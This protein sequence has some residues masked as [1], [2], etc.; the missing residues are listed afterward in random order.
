M[1]E[2][3]TNQNY[4]QQEEP[5]DIKKEAGYYLF[6]WPYFI[7]AL[8][9]VLVSAFLYLKTADRIYSSSAQ[10]Q[11]K[12]PAED[13]ASFLTGGMEFFG[14]DQV[15]VEND[16]AVLTSQHILSQ[17]VSRLDLQTKIYT[18]GRVNALLHFNDEY[19][20][21][22]TVKAANRYQY[23][24]VEIVDNKAKFSQD[25]LS[26]II[27]KGEKFVYNDTEITLNDSLFIEENTIIIERFSVN[28]AVADIRYNLMATPASK[29][30][31]IINLNF[32]GVNKQLNEAILNTVMQVMQ[33]DQVEDK[34]LI[35]EVSLEFI[36]DRLD[37]LTKTIDTLSQ[38]TIDFQTA[39]GIFD[40]EAQTGNALSNI[41]KGQEEAFSL[42]IQLEIAKALLEKLKSQ[43]S[44]QILPANI[45]IEN[46]SVTT[47]VNSYNTVVTQRNNLLISA[48]SKSP[49][50]MQLSSQ[51]DNAKAA[52]ITG[53]DRYVEGL[54]TS[55][56]GFKN[57]EAKTKGIV[58]GLPSKENTLRAYA[59]DFKIVE[60]LYVFLLE[61][62][63]EA[64]I[65]Y[66][67]ALPNIKLL[68]YGVSFKDPISPNVK[69]IYLIAISLGFFIPFGILF[70]LKMLDS[71]IN[72]RD[73][74]ENGLK[75]I[76]VLGEMPF[77]ENAEDLDDT[78]RGLIAESA[79]VLRSGLSFQLKTDATNVICVT[80]TIKG[81]GKS[82]VSFN[83]AQSYSAL[84]KKV[85][86]V[87]AD[88][89]NPQLHKFLNQKRE[90]TG[91]TTYLSNENFNDIDSL[92]TKSTKSDGL[93]YL[94]TGAI[95][96]NPSEL[97]M[98][99][100][101]KELLDILKQSYDLILID[102][103]PLLLVSDT[104]ALLPL[105]DSVVYVTR[106]QYS[107]K[108]TFSFI[109]N[110]QQRENVPPFG[111]VLNGLRAGGLTGS[112]YGYKYRYSYGYT[113]NYGYGYGY[114]SDADTES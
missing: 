45:G 62:K 75:G 29:K 23:W 88:L 66:I 6:F 56:S 44:Y 91:L 27:N 1:Q 21:F 102:S 2:D 103:A 112:N 19:N 104:T 82:F 76:T 47:L 99:S 93:D 38:N 114:G 54:Q 90:N 36:N 16:I 40:P 60:E 87:G 113:Y 14:F 13:A 79:R 34:R 65:S 51:L 64:S 101:T 3:L 35:S 98:R 31:E 33:D 12:K 20:K 63:E 8:I 89:R 17:V 70:L 77:A 107:E 110:M 84:G 58:A 30:G 92:I 25:T 22:I 48:T 42:G 94:L 55:L 41:V 72:T 81:E 69:I 50:V 46:E 74:L 71:K 80:S 106:S 32:V 10:L 97:L 24:D 4:L 73:D 39:N 9:I 67:S 11:I 108:K 26:F 95:P 68:S 61:R 7:A 37:G 28:E 15:N 53:V 59:R 85:I 49:M 109:L 96:P 18:V 111:M 100:R 78:G 5:I 52:I 105:C 43:A 86:L 83:L 57:M